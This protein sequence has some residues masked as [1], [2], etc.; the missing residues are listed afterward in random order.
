MGHPRRIHVRMTCPIIYAVRAGGEQATKQ[1][2]G[3]VEYTQLLLGFLNFRRQPEERLSAY[4]CS[5]SMYELKFDM[6][7]AGT[8]RQH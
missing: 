1:G 4:Y 6:S 7:V 3:F 2:I 8:A 5:S